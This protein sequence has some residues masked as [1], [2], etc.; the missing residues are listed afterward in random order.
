M[1]QDEFLIKPHP[2]SFKVL[3]CFFGCFFFLNL[4]FFFSLFSNFLCIMSVFVKYPLKHRKTYPAFIQGLKITAQPHNPLSSH[5]DLESDWFLS[6]L[7]GYGSG[8]SFSMAMSCAYCH[9]TE[10]DA[11]ILH[12]EKFHHARPVADHYRPWPVLAI[13]FFLCAFLTG[14]LAITRTLSKNQGLC[15]GKPKY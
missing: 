8:I 11:I 6:S 15:S 10:W 1:L 7:H 4:H 14:D 3:S 13:Q 12:T 5:S 9:Q 2:S